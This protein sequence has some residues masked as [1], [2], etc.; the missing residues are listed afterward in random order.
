VEDNN[1][2]CPFGIHSICLEGK[3]N[4]GLNPGQWYGP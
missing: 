4:I 2:F 1:V 3:T